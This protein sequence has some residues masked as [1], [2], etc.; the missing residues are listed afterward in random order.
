MRLLEVGTLATSAT[1]VA[2]G[3]SDWL[4]VKHTLHMFDTSDPP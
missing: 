1:D 3:G 4:D 2:W